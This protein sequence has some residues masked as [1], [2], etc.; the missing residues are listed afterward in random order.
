MNW[1]AIIKHSDDAELVYVS[2]QTAWNCDAELHRFDYD[3]SDYLIDA[4]GNIFT[5]SSRDNEYVKPE[6]NGNAMALPEILGL[7]KAHAA[8]KGSCCVAKLYAPTIREAF[9]IVESLDEA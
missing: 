6:P 9:K 2:D 8:Q 7:I 5:L 4:S 1:P 3:E